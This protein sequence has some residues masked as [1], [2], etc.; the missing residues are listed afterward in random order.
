V[1]PLEMEEAEIELMDLDMEDIEE[2]D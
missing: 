2:E 1:Y